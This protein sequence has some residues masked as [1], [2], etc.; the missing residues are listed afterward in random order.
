MG[1]SSSDFRRASAGRLP[2]VV[3]AVSLAVASLL[4]GGPA[5]AEG[6]T[7]VA[8][9]WDAFSGGTA[10]LNMRGRIEIADTD[11]R[12]HSEAYTV[13]TRLGYGT[14]PF[15]GFSVYADFENVAAIKKERYWNVVDPDNGKTPVPDPTATELNQAYLKFSRKD[16]LGSAALVG[17]QRIKLDDDRFI[18]NVGW[19]QNEQTYTGVLA[20]TSFGIDGLQLLYSYIWQVNS[21]LATNLNTSSHLVNL[22]YSSSDVFKISGFGYFLDFNQAPTN[23]SNSVGIRVHGDIEIGDDFSLGYQ[24]SE[25]YQWDGGRD[26]GT[27]PVDYSANYFMID[28]NFGFRPVGTLGGGYENLGSDNGEARFVTPLA[29]A[30]KFNGWADVFIRNG[31]VADPLLG[32]KDIYVYVVPKLPWSLEGKLVYHHFKTDKGSITLGNEFDASLKRPINKHCDVLAKVA[33]YNAA[34]NDAGHVVRGWMQVVL[35]F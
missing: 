14:K 7:W 12:E 11:T 31:P 2:G 29:T 34:G 21:I 24:V 28:M 23:S 6:K 13:R 19:R 3:I 15:Y 30:H 8:E 27:N 20:K 10:T 5:L 33:Y 9:F 18:G 1:S 32:L 16:F 17:V 35:K 25:A 4:V 22:S 26:T